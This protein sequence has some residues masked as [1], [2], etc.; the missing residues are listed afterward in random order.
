MRVMVADDSLIFRQ[1]VMAVL[2]G[3]GFDVVA[4]VDNATDLVRRVAGL[5]PDV[6]VVDIRMPPTHTDEGLRAAVEIGRRHPGV[7]V[8]VLS[9]YIEPDFA[10]RLLHEG[11]TGR[12]YLL[13]DRISCVEEFAEAVRRVGD[14]GSV[15]DPGVVGALVDRPAAAGPLA[16]L[17]AREVEI[18][19][20]IAEGRSNTWICERLSLS[21]RTVEAHTRSVFSKLALP[22]TA[23]DNRRVLAVLTYLRAT[24]TR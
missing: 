8:L 13:K 21:V 14:G 12:G 23:D 17:T 11:L 2:A 19:R 15:V 16:S 6:A 24:S 4:D 9:Q 7:G 22:A 20:M 1:G 18:L 5:K 3:A 10:V